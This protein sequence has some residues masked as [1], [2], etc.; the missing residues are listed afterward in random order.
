MPCQELF[1]LHVN[2]QGQVSC[3]LPSS[4]RPGEVLI[5]WYWLYLP[6]LPLHM[7]LTGLPIAA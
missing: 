2:G 7:W 1:L 5:I 6:I 4:A 3:L